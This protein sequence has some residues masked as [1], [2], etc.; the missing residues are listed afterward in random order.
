MPPLAH[1]PRALMAPAH[2]PPP[3]ARPWALMAPRPKGAY[4]P[5]PAPPAPWARTA[6][7]PLFILIFHLC[8]TIARVI[9]LPLFVLDTDIGCSLENF[10][11]AKPGP[12]SPLF[13]FSPASVILKAGSGNLFAKLV[14][15]IMCYSHMSVYRLSLK[16]FHRFRLLLHESFL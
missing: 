16:I 4:G 15:A 7:R 8:D 12:A 9:T 13:A 1:R 5:R 14:N 11:D 6:P 10:T 2:R 3:P